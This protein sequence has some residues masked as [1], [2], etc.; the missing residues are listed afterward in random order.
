[1][2]PP[3]SPSPP[4]DRP[5][6]LSDFPP[7]EPR[8]AQ[9]AGRAQA[10]KEE[11]AQLAAAQRES[12]REYRREQEARERAAAEERRLQALVSPPQLPPHAGQALAARESRLRAGAA[13]LRA[14]LQLEREA[15]SARPSAPP[16]RA[17]A[18][19]EVTKV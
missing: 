9:D 1:M 18:A 6:G 19:R 14:E 10:L 17:P 4:R 13:E 2:E 16:V 8:R 3:R 5:W 7:P 12:A 15:C 11:Q